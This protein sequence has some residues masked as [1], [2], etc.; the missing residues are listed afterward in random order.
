MLVFLVGMG[1]AV[2]CRHHGVFGEAEFLYAA[3]F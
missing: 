3:F 1:A 2:E